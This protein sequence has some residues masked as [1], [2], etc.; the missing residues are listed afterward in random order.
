MLAFWIFVSNGTVSSKLSIFS[1]ILPIITRSGFCAV[2]RRLGGTVLHPGRVWDG[3]SAYI[4]NQSISINPVIYL[5]R[6]LCLQVYLFLCSATLQPYKIWFV[7]SCRLPCNSAPACKHILQRSDA[8]FPHCRILVCVGR[9]SKQELS[10]N[11]NLP[12]FIF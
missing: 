4:K 8:D 12:F 5:I 11:F 10:I 6:L 1:S 2:T 7:V 9:V 3:M